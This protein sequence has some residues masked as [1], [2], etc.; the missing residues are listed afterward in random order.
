MGNGDTQRDRKKSQSFLVR[1]WLTRGPIILLFALL[2][3][4]IALT[5]TTENFLS[6]KNIEVLSYGI[7]TL[8]VVGFAQMVVLAAGG[9][10]VSVG[11]IGGL[12]AVLIGGLMEI[13]GVPPV[14][15]IIAGLLLGI[16]CGV[17]NGI[18]IV[19]M[20]LSPFIIT[21]ATASIFTGINLGLTSGQPF[22][23]LPESFRNLGVW[24][25]AG[26]PGLL[27]IMLV[28]AGILYFIFKS[29]GVGRQIL[30]MGANTR[31][32]ELAG[33]PINRTQII[34]HAMSGFL[35]A[36]SA[37]ILTARI[38]AAQPSIGNEWLLASFA[39]PI[40]GGTSL[41]GGALSVP[42]TVLGALL[43]TLTTNGLVH[44]G[45]DIYWKQLFSGLIILGAGGID[46]IRTH[47]SRRLEREQRLAIF[48]T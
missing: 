8:A 40:I 4:S 48:D 7:S 13:Y 32:A 41:L 27:I 29:T 18:L 17:L 35:A 38:G 21:I 16:G 15:A 19:R 39:A 9:M 11:A 2:V 34:V 14:L 25:I 44:L 30:A 5:A 33:V 42:G 46:L 37:I 1:R 23:N 45:I 26:V 12:V 43:L 20:Q 36:T 31:T 47:S 6:I 24:N 22:Y 10:N 28:I 3:L